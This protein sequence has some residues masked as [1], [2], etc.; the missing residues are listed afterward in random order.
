MSVKTVLRSDW[1]INLQIELRANDNT[2]CEDDERSI[3]LQRARENG[4]EQYKRTAM[5]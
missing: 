1:K 3:V 2:A 5:I 4:F